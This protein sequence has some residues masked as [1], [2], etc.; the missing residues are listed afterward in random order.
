MKHRSRKTVKPDEQNT[1]FKIYFLIN[2]VGY[3]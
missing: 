3:S 2:N 1:P